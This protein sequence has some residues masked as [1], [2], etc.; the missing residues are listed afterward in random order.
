M[1]WLHKKLRK[2]LGVEQNETD[3]ETLNRL[4]SDL[5]S[6]GIDIHFKNPH[7][8][9]IFSKIN[10]GQ[11]RHIDADFK[12]LRELNDFA[13]WLKE[14]YQTREICWDAPLDVK[15][16]FSEEMNHEL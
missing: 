11:I 4:Y 1:N 16:L 15:K 8:I 3:I 6:I 10:G 2:W 13:R 9:L 7:M 14:K 12:D 5:V